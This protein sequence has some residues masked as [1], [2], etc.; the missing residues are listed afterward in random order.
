MSRARAT[1]AVLVSTLLLPAAAGAAELTVAIGPGPA[2]VGDRI[3][4]VLV[5]SVDPGELDGQPRF[6]AWDERWG[7]AEIVEAGPVARVVESGGEGGLRF[8]QRLVLTAFRTGAVE[9]P[10][11]QVAVPGKG[12]T[13]ELWTPEGLALHVESVLPAEAGSGELEARPPAPPEPLPLG[14]AFWWTLAA[15]SVLT[16]GAAFLARRR[17]ASRAAAAPPRSPRDELD[18]SL[19]AAAREPAAEA[20]HVLLSLALR[21]FLGRKLGFPAA[22]STTAEIRRQLRGRRCSPGLEARAHEVL[23]ACDRVKFAREPTARPALEARIEAAR[24]IA[25]G[26]EDHLRPR[27]PGDATGSHGGMPREEAA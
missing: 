14:R 1:A 25:G 26:I 4:A 5:L 7:A 15:L 6:P 23:Q 21:R 22:E 9:L 18:A 13:A 10:P 17:H 8:R 20:G 3:E 24:E 11:K 27:P 19:A 16:A 2:T 12:A